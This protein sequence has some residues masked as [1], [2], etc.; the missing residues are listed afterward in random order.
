MPAATTKLNSSENINGLQ[1]LYIDNVLK[2]QQNNNLF[3]G[4]NI[5]TFGVDFNTGKAVRVY[6]DD[7]AVFN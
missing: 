5:A 1:Q 6:V 3:Y 4:A 2:V 7:V